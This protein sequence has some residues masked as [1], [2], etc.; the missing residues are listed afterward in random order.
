MRSARQ[1]AVCAPSAS[2]FSP[3]ALVNAMGNL[4]LAP[5]QRHD[6]HGLTRC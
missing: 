1:R 6:E 3:M 2:T 4:V 5:A